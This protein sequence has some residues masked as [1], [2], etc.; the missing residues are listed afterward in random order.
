M[1]PTRP[2]EHRGAVQLSVLNLATIV[3]V[4]VVTIYVLTLIF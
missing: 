3:L 4:V 1:Q 2:D